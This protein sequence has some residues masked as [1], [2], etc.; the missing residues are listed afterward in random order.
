MVYKCGVAPDY[1]VRFKTMKLAATVW[2]KFALPI[3]VSKF[4]VLIK[5]QICP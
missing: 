2:L 3:S 1:L 4:P 5:L